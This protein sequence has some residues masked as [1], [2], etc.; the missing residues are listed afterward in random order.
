VYRYPDVCRYRRASRIAAVVPLASA[1]SGLSSV[2]VAEREAHFPLF[3][4]FPAVATAGSVNFTF[5]SLPDSNTTCLLSLTAWP[6]R[7]SAIF[8]V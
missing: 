8:T 5:T 4:Y 6:S 2:N 3:P 7:V 1:G